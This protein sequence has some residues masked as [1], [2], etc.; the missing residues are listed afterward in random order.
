M[1]SGA[2]ITAR[3]QGLEQLGDLVQALR[4]MAGSRVHQA[5]DAL[6]GTKGFRKTIES[7]IL[8]LHAPVQA[9]GAGACL[10]V[11]TSETGFV[12]GFNNRIIEHVKAVRRPEERLVVI[13]RR[14]QILAAEQGLVVDASFQMTSRADGV[15]IL[16]RRILAD[17]GQVAEVRIIFAAHQQGGT[18]K[19]TER[20]ILPVSLTPQTTEMDAPLH[21]L[22]VQTLMAQLSQEYLFAEVA[23]ALMES[24]V[25]ENN[26]RLMT[27]DAAARNIDETLENLRREERTAR[28]EQITTDMLD[29]IVGV[30]ALR[31]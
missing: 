17:V 28:Q 18:F 27:M 22:P 12:G 4:S 26:A 11:I 7:A 15:T 5:Q 13:G 21:H 1:T 25:S 14:G 31:H 16:A 23:Q 24:L 19:V 29:V 10:L 30:E 6:A 2:E 20:Q 8:S 3:L 9:D